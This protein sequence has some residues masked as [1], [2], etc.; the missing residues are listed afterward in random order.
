MVSLV[1]EETEGEEKIK[2]I[3]KNEKKNVPLGNRTQNSRLFR[4]EYL[5]TPA[6]ATVTSAKQEVEKRC[7]SLIVRPADKTTF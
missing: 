4:R 2:S 5:T 3:K 6:S 7:D 1:R